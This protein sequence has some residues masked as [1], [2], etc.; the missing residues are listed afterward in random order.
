MY[1]TYWKRDKNPAAPVGAY[2]AAA[3]AAVYVGG[4]N[5]AGFLW[6]THS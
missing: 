6:M 3:V 1:S 2:V 5:G 4:G